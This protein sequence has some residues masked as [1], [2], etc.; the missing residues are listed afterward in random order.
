V[1]RE[2]FQGTLTR[3]PERDEIP[4]PVPIEERLIIEYYS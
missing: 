2:R 1:N 3:M 4:L